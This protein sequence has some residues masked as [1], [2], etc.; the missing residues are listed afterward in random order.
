MRGSLARAQ[1]TVPLNAYAFPPITIYP[2]TCVPGDGTR[3]N[4][5]QKLPAETSLVKRWN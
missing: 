2:L 4:S 5:A 3:I 1:A